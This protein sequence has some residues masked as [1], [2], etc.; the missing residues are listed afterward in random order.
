MESWSQILDDGNSCDVLYLDFSKAFDRVPH[1]S[2][3]LLVKL[4]QLGIKGNVLSWIESFLSS[5]R[6]RVMV[7]G[8]AS[9]WKAVR[10]GVPQGSVLGPVLFLMFVNDLSD[11]IGSNVRLFA[12]DAKCWQPI[13]HPGDTLLLQETIH[14][15]EA[16]SSVW[17]LKFNHGKCHVMHHGRR[18]P[19][20]PYQMHLIEGSDQMEN[21]GTVEEEKDL[22]VYFSPNLNFT[23][24]AHKVAAKAN[25]I[26]G[27]IKRSF[28]HL[29]KNVF[30]LLYKALVRPHLEYGSCV[31]NEL[32]K[33]DA[34]KLESVQRR[35]TKLVPE[36]RL[37]S[38][39]DRLKYLGIPSL[40]YRRERADM[41]QV[42]KIL[43]DLEDFNADTLFVSCDQ[44]TRGHKFKFYKRRCRT[45]KRL[46]S[47]SQRVVNSWN[48]LPS[49]TAEASSL[50][51][52]KSKLNDHWKQKS[53]KFEP[54]CLN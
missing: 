28:V 34:S 52:F 4:K 44:I 41:V 23:Q 42:F 48:S 46:H 8:E 3:R 47:F 40:E 39:P 15:L 21:I 29:S 10:S 30:V 43:N 49:D 17:Q 18:N 11:D 27:L 53:N 22:G 51:I 50:N 25:R 5:R 20:H 12:D 38:Y 1:Q 19:Q 7:R 9:S 24:H 13:N 35:A 26:I 36:A 33:R 54:Q 6:Q 31:W 37:L 2:Q 16:W 14:K 45:S 32:S